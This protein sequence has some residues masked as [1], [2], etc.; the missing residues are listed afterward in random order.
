[1]CIWESDGV[2]DHLTCRRPIDP[3]PQAKRPRPGEG[4]SLS[5][6]R[7]ALGP[8]L[9]KFGTGQA[10]PAIRRPPKH[11]AIR[12]ATPKDEIPIPDRGTLLEPCQA[13]SEMSRRLSAF[14]GRLTGARLATPKGE[15]FMTE[16]EDI[17]VTSEMIA[18]SIEAM[19]FVDET[20]AE[21]FVEVIYRADGAVAC[22]H[23]PSS[24]WRTICAR[25]FLRNGL[26]S[27]ST[28]AASRPSCIM[29][30]SA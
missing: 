22:S 2:R 30:F 17:V 10:T 19:A 3:N 20:S 28:P 6:C 9:E 18:A 1:M 13:R 29:A 8:P 15:L 4:V 21:M 14:G 16:P 12:R 27:S 11:R 24:A 26:F 5:H 25:S 23:A 7:R